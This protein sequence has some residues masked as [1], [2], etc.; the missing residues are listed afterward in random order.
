[1]YTRYREYKRWLRK[2]LLVLQVVKK[3]KLGPYHGS[4]DDPLNVPP[5]TWDENATHIVWRDAEVTDLEFIIKEK[6]DGAAH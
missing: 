4:G 5:P 6:H 2:S 3:V 1:M